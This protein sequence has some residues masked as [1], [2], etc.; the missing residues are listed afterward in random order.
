M[1]EVNNTSSIKTT[2]SNIDIEMQEIS[3][4]IK[5]ESDFVHEKKNTIN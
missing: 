2:L 4:L 1:G 5:K 3:S